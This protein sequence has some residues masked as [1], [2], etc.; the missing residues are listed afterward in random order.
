MS[1]DFLDRVEDL[2]VIIVRGGGCNVMFA[3]A[4]V[5]GDVACA[6]IICFYDGCNSKFVIKALYVASFRV[7]TRARNRL[8]T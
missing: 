1:F 2:K 5:I 4:I 3:F 8:V 6:V 7:Y